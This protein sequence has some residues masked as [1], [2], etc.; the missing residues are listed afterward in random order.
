MEWGTGKGTTTSSEAFHG[1]PK[2]GDWINMECPRVKKVIFTKVQGSDS[3]QLSAKVNF[4][5]VVW[6]RFVRF[7]L[8]RI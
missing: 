1:Y 5:I 3:Q 2:V 6:F 4:C 8:R 7:M